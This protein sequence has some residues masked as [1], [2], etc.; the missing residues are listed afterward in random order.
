MA[1]QPVEP[2]PLPEEDNVPGQV[3]NAL[4][5]PAPLPLTEEDDV[6]DK[7][8]NALKRAARNRW[9]R[10]SANAKSEVKEMRTL[11]QKFDGYNCP[12][13]ADSKTLAKFYFP[14][15][16]ITILNQKMRITGV[17]KKVAKHIWNLV[18]RAMERPGFK[19]AFNDHK[20]MYPVLEK[21]KA[22]MESA[23]G[24]SIGPCPK[25]KDSNFLKKWES[26]FERKI[27]IRR[28]FWSFHKDETPFENLKKLLYR[29]ALVVSEVVIPI[30]LGTYKVKSIPMKAQAL[31][32]EIMLFDVAHHTPPSD[33][34]RVG[35]FNYAC[36]V[37]LSEAFI[38]KFKTAYNSDKKAEGATLYSTSMVATALNPDM[39][40]RWLQG[41]LAGVD[42]ENKPYGYISRGRE[43]VINGY[44][45]RQRLCAP[46]GNPG[47]AQGGA[48]ADS[49]PSNSRV[50]PTPHQS[51]EPKTNVFDQLAEMGMISR[52]TP[53]SIHK[54][55]R[56]EIVNEVEAAA[57][58][59]VDIPNFEVEIGDKGEDGAC[60][61]NFKEQVSKG[62]VL[63]YGGM[64]SNPRDN[65]GE[66]SGGA[67]SEGSGGTDT[68][69][70]VSSLVDGNLLDEM[71]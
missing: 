18:V 13:D 29:L 10:Y 25:K 26:G 58:E 55:M 64:H 15:A 50:F 54:G 59:I 21:G 31:L 45:K 36:V 16:G 9:H 20:D 22:L 69:L 14:V 43:A 44:V 68:G 30:Q 52:G 56:R 47:G 2:L 4:K 60:L 11:L 46:D 67:A 41:I 28:D 71:W 51:P 63:C 19:E 62:H 32:C 23:K 6:P 8:L 65:V 17:N 12:L 57:G 1:G 49:T 3:L 40:P 42:D 24:Y 5:R 27:D 7:V 34:D 66:D 48:N 53:D 61:G 33:V 38:K 35:L 70:P 39:L 37:Y